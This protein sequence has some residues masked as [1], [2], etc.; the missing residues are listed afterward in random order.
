MADYLKLPVG[1][2]KMSNVLFFVDAVLGFVW[3]Q[4]Q[5]AAGMGKSTEK[6]LT[7]IVQGFEKPRVWQMDGGSHFKGPELKEACERL[8]ITRIVMPAYTAWV[9]GLVEGVNKLFLSCLK[10]KCAP[11]LDDS[12]YID[13]DPK[14]IPRN[15]PDFLRNW[16]Q[17]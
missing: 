6:L 1:K 12:E 13:V 14:S 9:N 17:M 15:W 2:N 5:V 4:K 3:G 16:L 7:K 11:D 8:G 10:K